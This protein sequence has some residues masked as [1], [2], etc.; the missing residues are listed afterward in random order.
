MKWTPGIL[1]DFIRES[2]GGVVDSRK[3]KQMFKM[4]IFSLLVRPKLA[5]GGLQVGKNL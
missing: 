1:F 2:P 4:G 5:Q 3:S